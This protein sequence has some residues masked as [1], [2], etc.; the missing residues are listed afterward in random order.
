MKKALLVT[1]ISGF[2]PQFE[3]NDV[4]ILKEYGY[5][6]HY[7]SNFNNPVYGIDSEQLQKEGIILH[8]IDIMKSPLRLLSNIK[9][10]NKLR[11]II[12]QEHIE[13]IHCHTPMGSIVAR[14]AAPK[15]KNRP[16]VI[17]TAHGFHFYK[18][19][20]LINRMLYYPVERLMAHYTDHL[21]T[22]NHEDYENACRM[23]LRKGGKVS[24][25]NGVGVDM[26][27]FTT[28]PELRTEVRKELGIPE[29]AL[30]IVTVAELNS[31]KN[32]LIIINAIAKI[33]DKNIYYS[34]CGNGPYRKKLSKKITDLHLNNRVKLLGY[35]EDIDRILQGA[36]CFAFPSKRE[37]L[38]LAAVEALA[39]GVPVIA[40]LNR[41]TREYMTDFN[42][43]LCKNNQIEEYVSA[44]NK[45]KDKEYR[46]SI[47]CQCRNSVRQFSIEETD[48][49]MRGI[50]Q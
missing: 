18:G 24:L 19:A 33:E 25:I 23:H 48:R 17:Y 4:R 45:M 40:A 1:T 38:G 34:I 15:K 14:I 8:H 26:T 27:K 16:Y 43:I 7:A 22:I 41:G 3:M 13:L 46:K 12:R 47:S 32:Q 49:R 30:H 31:N 39:C 5:E 21:I 11:K 10:V 20:P 50:Y 35:R 9:A 2:V 28:R 6:V 29:D 44:I 36:D 37:G 42:G